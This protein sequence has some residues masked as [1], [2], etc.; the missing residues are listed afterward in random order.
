MEKNILSIAILLA[1]IYG[2]FWLFN[3]VNP[4]LGILT[5]FVVVY[6]FIK[7]CITTKN[8]KK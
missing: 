5:F 4:W 3:H 7:L 1:A 8:K 2:S 6:V